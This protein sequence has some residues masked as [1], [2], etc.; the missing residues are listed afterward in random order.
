MQHIVGA[1]S[2]F[3]GSGTNGSVCYESGPML[4]LS[5]ILDSG[6]ISS[7]QAVLPLHT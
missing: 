2:L 5:L 7:R 1:Q 6:C 4:G 3:I